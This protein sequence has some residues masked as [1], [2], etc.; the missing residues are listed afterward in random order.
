MINLEALRRQLPSSMVC[1]LEERHFVHLSGPSHRTS[2]GGPEEKRDAVDGPEGFRFN[3]NTVD[4]RQRVQAAADAPEI[5]AKAINALRQAIDAQAIAYHSFAGGTVA[6]IRNS[7]DPER[8][9]DQLGHC[10][11]VVA[12]L[13]QTDPNVP[14]PEPIFLRA[15]L[16]D[17]A[18]AAPAQQQAG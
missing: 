18:V 6:I 2:S 14:E 17:R 3:F 7:R 16:R 8:C 13:G 9:I 15:Y 5:A 10:R 4:G 12:A 11:R 1:A